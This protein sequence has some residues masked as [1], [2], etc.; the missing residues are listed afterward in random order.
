MKS[1]ILQVLGLYVCFSLSLDGDADDQCRDVYGSESCFCRA[2]Y[3]S[4][5]FFAAMCRPMNGICKNTT[6]NEC[7]GSV[8]FNDFTV[9]GDRKW[10]IAGECIASDQAP[11]RPSDACPQLDDPTVICDATVCSFVSASKQAQCCSSC[12]AMNTTVPTTTPTTSTTTAPPTTSPT[13][14]PTTP[15]ATSPT[16]TLTTTFPSTTIQVLSRTTTRSLPSTCSLLRFVYYLCNEAKYNSWYEIRR[17]VT[18]FLRELTVRRRQF[19]I[20]G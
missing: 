2:S 13:T 19:R 16:T 11:S 7:S 17:I 15:L 3:S 20:G 9:C 8:T 14:S 12:A 5:P 4:E 6:T 18:Q 10:C 1:L